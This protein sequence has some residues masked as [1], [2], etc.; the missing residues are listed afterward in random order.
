ME[1]AQDHVQWLNLVLAV[2]NLWVYYHRISY[3]VN[4]KEVLSLSCRINYWTDWG[5]VWVRESSAHL[6]GF[7]DASQQHQW[8][9]SLCICTSGHYRH[10]WGQLQ[11]TSTTKFQLV[12][13]PECQGSS[14][15]TTYFSSPLWYFSVCFKFVYFLFIVSA[16]ILIDRKRWIWWGNHVWK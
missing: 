8:L 7:Y 1:L 10:I 2:F 5:Y 15:N 4:Y 16:K 14:R 3:S 6:W 12:A 11:G 13:S 9:S